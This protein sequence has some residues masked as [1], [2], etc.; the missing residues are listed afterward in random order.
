LIPIIDNFFHG[1]RVVQPKWHSAE[2]SIH[3]NSDG[4]DGMW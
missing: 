4:S 1:D 3:I 2:A